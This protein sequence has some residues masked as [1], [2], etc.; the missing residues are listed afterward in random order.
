VKVKVDPDP[1]NFP[2][3]LGEGRVGVAHVR[4]Y[5]QGRVRRPWAPVRGGS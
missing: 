5:M 2:P 1:R 3:P 4:Y